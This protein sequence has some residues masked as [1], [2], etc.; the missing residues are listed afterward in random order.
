MIEQERLKQRV[1]ELEIR[2]AHQDRTVE[3]LNEALAEQWR[4]VDELTRKLALLEHRL[5][6][7]EQSSNAAPSAEPPPPH[8]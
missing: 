1:D 6:S 3:E 4:A 2:I 7:L 8:Y 5:L